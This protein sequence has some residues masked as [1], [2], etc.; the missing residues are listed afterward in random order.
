MDATGIYGLLASESTLAGIFG[1]RI[2]PVELTIAQ[3]MPAL[4]YKVIGGSSEPTF[5]TSGFQRERIELNSYADTYLQADQGREALLEFLNGYG[6]VLAD[7]TVLQN[8]EFIQKLDF[9]EQ[10]PR[11]FRCMVEFYFYFDF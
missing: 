9:Y 5:D 4:T 2:E 7:G 6:G 8:V 11:R 1:D 3:T 10:A